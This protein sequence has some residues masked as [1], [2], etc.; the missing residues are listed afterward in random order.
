MLIPK[1]ILVGAQLSHFTLA[2]AQVICLAVCGQM[3]SASVGYPDPHNEEFRT[4]YQKIP[5][6][7]G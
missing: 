1:E 3:M 4:C 6:S 7:C 2:K 5:C